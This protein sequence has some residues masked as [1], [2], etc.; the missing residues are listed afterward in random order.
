MGYP[1]H[2]IVSRSVMCFYLCICT[3]FLSLYIVTCELPNKNDDDDVYHTFTNG[4]DFVDKAKANESRFPVSRYP[5]P[6]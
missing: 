3:V 2:C 5:T 6:P 4:V 1:W